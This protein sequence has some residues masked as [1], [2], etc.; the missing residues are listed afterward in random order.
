MHEFSA[1]IWNRFENGPGYVSLD[2][3]GWVTCIKGCLNPFFSSGCDMQ[4]DSQSLSLCGGA[5]FAGVFAIT[6]LAAKTRKSP[7]GMSGV[8]ISLFGLNVFG[9]GDGQLRQPSF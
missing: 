8:T 2:G 1:L 3:E 7:F 6:N 9:Q 4:R 5:V